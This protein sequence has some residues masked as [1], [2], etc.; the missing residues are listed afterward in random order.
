MLEARP[1]IMTAV[2]RLYETMHRRILTGVERQ[3]GFKAKLFF[4]ALEL[5]RKRYHDPKSLTLV[6]RL[7]DF[8]V[9]RLVRNKVRGR[10]GGRLK[11]LVSGGAALNPEIGLF[12]TALG[13]KL[14]QGYGQTE[15]APVVACNRPSRVRLETVGPPLT[16]VEVKTGED[17]E[18]LVRGELV[19]QGYWNDPAA[20]A[21][22]I[23]DGW[24][25]TGDIGVIDPDGYIRIT[26]RK[27][28]FIKNSGGDMIAPAKVEGALV[29]EPEI[30]QAMV[31][32]D[33][34]PHLVAVLVPHPDVIERF[35]K[36]AGKPA[37]L[38]TL[39]EDA[40][41]RAALDVVVQRVNAKL[42][43]AE[44]VRRFIVAQEPFSVANELM[45]PTLKV[46]RHKVREIY[47]AKLEA[48]YDR[49]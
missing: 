17:G 39:A 43:Q 27:K 31:H 13:L 49:G 23:K 14:L 46:K 1:T 3:G 36:S 47:G 32:G 2:P 35:A 33:R 30:A 42:P 4:K 10:F 15:S 29:L 16:E 6:E 12:F 21:A 8:I 9:D 11:A 22:A 28:D 18:I 26:D 19:M 20:T 7:V 34:R 25:H 38:D 40:G 45:T 41:L 5:G 44:R 48:L 24:L 37:A